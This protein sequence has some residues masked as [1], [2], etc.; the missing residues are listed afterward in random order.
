MS[1]KRLGKGLQALIPSV[2]D[3]NQGVTEIN[4]NRILPNP[5]QPRRDFDDEKLEELAASIREHGVIQ[6]IIVRENGDMYELV[7]GERRWRAAKKLGHTTIPAIIKEYTD[8]EV[9]E[10]ALIENLQRE[11]LNPIEEAAAYK[12]LMEEFGLTQDELSKKIGKSRSLIANSIRLLNLPAEIQELLE[13]GAITT[14]HARSLLSLD[15]KGMQMEL[16]RRIIEEGLTVRDIEKIV[17]KAAV[18]K[19][20]KT[21]KAPETKDPLLLDIEERLKMVLGTQVRIKNGRNKGKIEIEY[22]SGEDLERII[23]IFLKNN[24]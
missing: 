2:E 13:K 16:A 6:P 3:E 1:K 23:E 22:Y 15:D 14:G 11:D 19:D 5:H 18:E 9:M 8:G 17:K 4:I 24:I 20:K 21:K 10:I 7:A 12:Q